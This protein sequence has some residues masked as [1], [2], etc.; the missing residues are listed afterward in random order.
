[1]K[2][3]SS[4]R[5]LLLIATMLF[6]ILTC[7]GQ[8]D[9]SDQ[10]AGTWTKLLGERS[11]TLT[12][13]TDKKFQV[14]FAGDDE[15]DVWGSYVISGTQITFKDEGGDYSS[16]VEGVYEFKASDTSI[17]FTKINDPVEGRSMLLAGSWSKAGAAEK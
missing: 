17:T 1:M 13:S 10:V 8:N 2:S 7:Y 16:N 12:L 3:A 11:I 4:T 5:T 14:E 15:V 9:P 6:S